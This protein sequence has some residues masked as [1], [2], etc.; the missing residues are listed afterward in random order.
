MKIFLI[1]SALFFH[2]YSVQLYS[3]VSW[4]VIKTPVDVNLYK[5]TYLDS[6][7]LWAAGD[8][9]TIIFS[10]NQ[11]ESWHI[12]SDLL[13]NEIVD[14]FFINHSWGWALT[15]YFDGLNLQSQI[16]SSSDGGN[17][18]DR[19]N[20][21][22]ANSVLQTIFFLDSL[23]GW[24]AGNPIDLSF[25]TDGGLT[26]SPANLDTSASCTFP[27]LKLDFQIINMDLQS[28]EQ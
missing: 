9:G 6:L 11:G 21:Q 16:L 1:Y 5:V 2:T 26:W 10:S 4:E 25:T 27:F 7:H 3:Q 23:N 12:Q 13:E 19:Q 14:I 24:T 17:T 28:A 22:N 20:F 8:S 18:W 15:W